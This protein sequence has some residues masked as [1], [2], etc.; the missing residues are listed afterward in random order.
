MKRTGTVALVLV[1]GFVASLAPTS[2]SAQS[3]IS[4]FEGVWSGWLTT[5]EDPAWM[6]EDY[7]CFVGC[8]KVAYD[9]LTTLLDDPAN[10]ERPLGELTGETHDFI[11]TWLRERSTAAGIAMM[12]GNGEANDTNLEC[13]PYDFV[14][15][16]TNPLPF[17][18]IHNGDTLTFNYEEWNRTRTV[19]LDG[20]AFPEA[21]E[22]SSLGFSVGHIEGDMLVIETRGLVASTYPPITINAA[23]GHSD[24]LQG[25]ERYTVTPGETPMLTLELTL[26][27]PGT[28][29]EPYVYYKRWI[30]TPDIQILTDSCSDKPGVF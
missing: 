22:P 16:A 11:T 30:A 10:D 21:L 3:G 6:V 1:C 23:G 28:L 13:H 19:Y 7:L 12:D 27:D 8:P 20:R 9:H 18:I 24:R 25:I 5:Q 4:A 17:Q 26:E 15:S 14:R 29:T 2:G